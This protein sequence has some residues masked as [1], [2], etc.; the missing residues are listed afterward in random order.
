MSWQLALVVGVLGVPFFLIYLSQN[1]EGNNWYG[2]GVKIF[3]IFIAL[4][5]IIL[6]SSMNIHILTASNG[7]MT[8]TTYNALSNNLTTHMHYTVWTF[9]I[10]L[11]FFMLYF[12]YYFYMK[13]LV[14]RKDFGGENY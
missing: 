12:I 8:N 5:S 2:E 9:L 1:I 11:L 4:I 7:S 14:K 3:L 13:L 10:I 6:S